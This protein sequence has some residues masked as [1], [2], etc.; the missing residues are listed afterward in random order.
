M[1]NRQEDR[2]N[3]FKKRREE[4]RG[5]KSGWTQEKGWRQL[6]IWGATINEPEPRCGMYVSRACMHGPCERQSESPL[7]V[8]SSPAVG[9]L[10]HVPI[11]RG[12]DCKSPVQ[13]RIAGQGADLVGGAYTG[14]FLIS[15]CFWGDR[16][17]K[18]SQLAP[19]P[20]LG[21]QCFSGNLIDKCAYFSRKKWLLHDVT[22]SEHGFYAPKCFTNSLRLTITKVRFC[23]PKTSKMSK[24]QKSFLN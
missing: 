9:S 13:T 16:R 12:S 20:F 6:S 4:C 7:D 14:C 21:V 3:G 19:K 10:S 23:G 8:R 1:G 2:V 24:S 17:Q 18:V 11:P 5:R 22:L 15:T